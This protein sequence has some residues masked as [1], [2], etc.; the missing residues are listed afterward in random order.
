MTDHVISVMLTTL[1]VVLAINVV[2]L[3]ILGLLTVVH[4][5]FRRKP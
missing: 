2:L 1:G 5:F 4:D 3:A